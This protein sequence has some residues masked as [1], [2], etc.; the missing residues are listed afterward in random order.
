MNHIVHC[1]LGS[2][3]V[4][5]HGGQAR[6]EAAPPPRSPI[7]KRPGEAVVGVAQIGWRLGRVPCRRGG[8]PQGPRRLG[9]VESVARSIV[10][11]VLR[12]AR[13]RRAE[14]PLDGVIG[15]RR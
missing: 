1:H 14:V 11:S 13:P 4:R 7:D 10:A 5:H 12:R 6:K 3:W 15:E 8:Y 2:T 9:H